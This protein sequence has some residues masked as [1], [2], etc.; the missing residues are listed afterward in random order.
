MN[1]NVNLSGNHSSKNVK[2]FI[3]DFILIKAF[4][5]NIK[6]P[7]HPDIIEVIWTSS[8]LDWIKINIDGASIGNPESSSYGGIFIN[9]HGD[10]LGSF[11]IP[12]GQANV[13]SVELNVIMYIIKIVSRGGWNK[14]WIECDFKYALVAFTK[15]NLTR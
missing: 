6:P 8:A 5:V 2:C 9:K 3:S 7:K 15:P 13:F 4:K 1:I 11:V 12:L 10:H 14:L